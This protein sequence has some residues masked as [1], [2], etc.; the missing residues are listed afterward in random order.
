M[1]IQPMEKR[2]FVDPQTMGE[3]LERD[4]S[5]SFESSDSGMEPVSQE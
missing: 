5:G 3:E 2:L 1:D 4:R